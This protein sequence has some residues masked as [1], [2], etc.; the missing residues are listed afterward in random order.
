MEINKFRGITFR[1]WWSCSSHEL[2]SSDILTGVCCHQYLQTHAYTIYNNRKMLC[3]NCPFASALFPMTLYWM[4]SPHTRLV[5]CSHSLKWPPILGLALNIVPKRS[6]SS[7]LIWELMQSLIQYV[8]QMM[9]FHSKNISQLHLPSV[10]SPSRWA[11]TTFHQK[12]MDWS[13]WR[14]AVMGAVE[15]DQ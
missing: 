12:R 1:S 14:V 4:F 8:P 15:M 13:G 9:S 10:W 7:H 11:K 6:R 5:S 2:C 3:C